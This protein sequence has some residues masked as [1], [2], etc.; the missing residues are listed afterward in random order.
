MRETG[1]N[2]QALMQQ[3]E[4]EPRACLVGHPVAHSRSPL[5][6]DHWLRTLGLPG[7]YSLMD[8]P[9]DALPVFFDGMRAG[10]FRGCNVTVPHKEAVFAL[11]DEVDATARAVGAVN[12]VWMAG[13]RLVGG[14]TDVGGF[15]ASLDEQAP[16][17]SEGPARAVVL[18]AGGA[19][20]AVCHGLLSRGLSVAIVNR[21]RPRGEALV[22][23]L[24]GAVGAAIR[25]EPEDTL[26]ELLAGANL[27]VNTT[28][29]GMAGKPGLTID[30][31][32]LPK[33]AI[34][35]DIVYVPL[36]TPLLAAASA[37]GCRTVDGLG[38]LLHQAVEGFEHWFGVRPT[39]T[40]DLR[41]LVE[42][43]IAGYVAGQPS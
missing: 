42:A 35:C 28:S 31:G 5:I 2:W 37:K 13:S 17:W 26:A 32:P 9:P 38:M 33:T 1:P 8:I 40:A 10:A 14:N 41:R 19:A 7:S 34:V 22:T 24:G 36:V 20:R 25:T 16:G 3:H 4:T 15:L 29:L 12:T 23:A 39:V 6:H 30:L 18:G 11:V 27:L 43:D 21:T